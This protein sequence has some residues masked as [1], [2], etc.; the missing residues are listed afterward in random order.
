MILHIFKQKITQEAVLGIRDIWY[1]SGAE[2]P[3]LWLTD[4]A[5]LV[6]DL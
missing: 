2:N 6:S 5:I 3:Y 1:E 4:P